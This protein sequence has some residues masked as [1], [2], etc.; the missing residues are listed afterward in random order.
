MRLTHI[1]YSLLAISYACPLPVPI[2]ENSSSPTNCSTTTLTLQSIREQQDPKEEN[3]LLATIL[4]R[5]PVY[6][7]ARLSEGN[8][9]MALKRLT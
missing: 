8:T 2:D 1:I 3:V 5:S 7:C 4:G 9:S 6:V